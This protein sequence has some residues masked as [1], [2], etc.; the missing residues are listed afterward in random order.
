L[1]D[2]E[3]ELVRLGVGEM[4]VRGLDG[5][6]D[7][8]VMVEVEK[9]DELRFE[10]VDGIEGENGVEKEG[11]NGVEKERERGFEMVEEVKE[12]NEVEKVRSVG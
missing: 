10:M 9:V 1:E 4:R 8:V 11:E 3:E 6:R 5:V 2:E 7:D 12:E